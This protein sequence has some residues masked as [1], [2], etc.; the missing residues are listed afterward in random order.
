LE[1]FSRQRAQRDRVGLNLDFSQDLGLLVLL[2]EDL[3]Q[4]PFE[5]AR[6]VVEIPELPFYG[7]DVLLLALDLI[8]QLKVLSQGLVHLHLLLLQLGQCF[9]HLFLSHFVAAC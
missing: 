1:L 3:A 8:A 4:D 9:P 6:H 7:V 5:V 2:G